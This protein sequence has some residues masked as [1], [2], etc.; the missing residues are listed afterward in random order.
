M[1]GVPK[2]LWASVDR[3]QYLFKFVPQESNS[4]AELASTL[5]VKDNCHVNPNI[6]AMWTR[7]IPEKVFKIELG[8]FLV[9]NA[10]PLFAAHV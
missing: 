10:K 4:Q 1:S 5:L 3:P 6:S 8:T 2:V 9:E 7:R